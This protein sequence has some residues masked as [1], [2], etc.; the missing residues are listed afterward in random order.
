MWDFLKGMG[1]ELIPLA[2]IIGGLLTAVVAIVAT[3]WRRVR[4]AEFEASLKQ[5]MLERGLSAAEIEQVMK[6]STEYASS[7]G[8]LADL[9]AKAALT[10]GGPG[11]PGAGG[12]AVLEKAVLAEKMV[13]N[14]YEAK[15]IERVLKAFADDSAGRSDGN[16]QAGNQANTAERAALVEKM[17]EN[18]YEGE[19]IARVLEAFHKPSAGAAEAMATAGDEGRGGRP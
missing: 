12:H 13:E 19:D 2:A 5:Q 4:L 10:A 7:G 11:E 15:D 9:R 17:V 18:G 14:G 16:G 6:A 3:Q 1:D 8:S